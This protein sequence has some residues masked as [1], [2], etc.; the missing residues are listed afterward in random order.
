MLYYVEPW[1]LL[2]YGSG[3][4]DAQNVV[5][6]CFVPRTG[7]MSQIYSQFVP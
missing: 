2:C 5:Y 3:H 1:L 7:A 6:I 4:R